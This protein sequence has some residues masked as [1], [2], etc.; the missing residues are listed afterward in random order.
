M[1]VIITVV[2]KFVIKEFEYIGRGSPLGNPFN[3]RGR[4]D[5]ERD[6]V[7]DLYS[8]WLDEQLLTNQAIIDELN[9]L[10]TLSLTGPV[11]LGCFCAPKRC[12]GDRIK[13]ILLDMHA[14]VLG[15]D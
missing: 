5:A 2:N 12:H 15:G 14:G 8:T 13:Q 6:Q 1:N 9:R 11:N 7:C 10:Y 4:T 3:M